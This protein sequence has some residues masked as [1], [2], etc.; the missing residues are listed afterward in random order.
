MGEEMVRSLLVKL[1]S[2]TGVP[3]KHLMM[4][5]IHH[6]ISDGGSHRIVLRDLLTVY[7]AYTSGA[8]EPLGLPRLPLEYA[9]YAVWQWQQLEMGGHLEQ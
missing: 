1:P 9:D 2:E 5:A 4:I 3:N 8:D 7:R 6:A